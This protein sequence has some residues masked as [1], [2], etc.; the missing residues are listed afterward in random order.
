VVFVKYILVSVNISKVKKNEKN[1]ETE[2]NNEKQQQQLVRG[3]TLEL[4][5]NGA[6][7]SFF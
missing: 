5:F 2:K 6:P 4:P 3:K 1:D 7:Y